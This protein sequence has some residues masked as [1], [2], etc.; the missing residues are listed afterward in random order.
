M[1]SFEVAALLPPPEP[2]RP[3]EPRPDEPPPG[4]IE[5]LPAVLPVP[6]SLP[7]QLA[8]AASVPSD[9]MKRVNQVR[10]LTTEAS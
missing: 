6:S 5:P 7:Q 8:V 3:T 2:A 4:M 9:M 1:P 10:A